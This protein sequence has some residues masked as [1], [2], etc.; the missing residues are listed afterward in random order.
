MVKRIEAMSLVVKP[1]DKRFVPLVA[2]LYNNPVRKPLR[3]C[4]S[5]KGTHAHVYGVA[6]AY[7]V[8]A[9]T[10][11]STSPCSMSACAPLA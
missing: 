6:S 7:I 2:H 10:C 4:P 9:L 3:V 8:H 5:H 1:A 11:A